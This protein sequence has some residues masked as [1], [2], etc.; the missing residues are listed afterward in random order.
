MRSSIPTPASCAAVLATAALALSCASALTAPGRSVARTVGRH[1]R[2]TSM[3]TA[4]SAAPSRSND[5]GTLVEI[6]FKVNGQNISVPN[7]L[8]GLP[9]NREKIQR[10]EQ[11]A[12]REEGATLYRELGVPEDATYDEINAAYARLASVH[13]ND[14][15]RSIRL[16]ITKDKIV[17]LRLKQRVGGS[18]QVGGAARQIELRE[19]TKDANARKTKK[20]FTPPPFL[21]GLGWENPDK[22]HA[23]KVATYILPV[24]LADTI[25]PE[26]SSITIAVGTLFAF[27]ALNTR[28][29]KAF[30]PNTVDMQAM[31][32]G[33]RNDANA[34]KVGKKTAIVIFGMG[35][36]FA[37][38]LYLAL[39][40]FRVETH[41]AKYFAGRAWYLGIS[42]GALFFKT[43]SKAGGSGE[44]GK[45]RTGW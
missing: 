23:K 20:V 34:P 39:R 42:L 44:K 36:T 25:L 14:K 1:P 19:E 24:V 45:A 37:G 16:A 41:I 8:A 4:V 40:L 32:G 30:D 11:R 28:G 12:L 21:Q 33:G 17:E 5:I 38:P 13:E 31:M 27:Y 22:A 26:Y 10:R 2:V 18:L 3:S 7:P 6:P 43:Y 15:K 35:T 29:K 9:W